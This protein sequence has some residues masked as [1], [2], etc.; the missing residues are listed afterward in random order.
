[1]A[2]TPADFAEAISGMLHDEQQTDEIV[3]PSRLATATLAFL[4]WLV[5]DWGELP[6]A[7]VPLAVDINN[8]LGHE[9]YQQLHGD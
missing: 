4:Q 2:L 3:I 9:Q 5:E 7:M 1:M 8:N 6:E